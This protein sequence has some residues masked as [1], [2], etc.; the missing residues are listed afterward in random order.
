M[1]TD[2]FA[3]ITDALLVCDGFRVS[4]ADWLAHLHILVIC[5]S[6]VRN[7]ILVASIIM[8]L[9]SHLEQVQVMLLMKINLL[10]IENVIDKTKYAMY[11]CMWLI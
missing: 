5:T 11:Y 2:V 3:V 6:Y 8:L 10:Q 4:C 7:Y 9:Q 1:I